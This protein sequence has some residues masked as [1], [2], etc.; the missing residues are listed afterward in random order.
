MTL[1]HLTYLSLGH[2]NAVSLAPGSVSGGV[3]KQDRNSIS[4]D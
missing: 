2:A 1:T 3:E 4:V